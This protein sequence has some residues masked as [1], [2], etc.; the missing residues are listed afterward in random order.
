MRPHLKYIRGE[1]IRPVCDMLPKL[2]QLRILD[3]GGGH[4]I[5]ANTIAEI[6]KCPVDV[7]DL[8]PGAIECGSWYQQDICKP[9]PELQN[10]YTTIFANNLIHFLAER[11]QFYLAVFKY[12]RN[13]GR[14]V[15]VTKSHQ[16][17]RDRLVMSFFQ[18]SGEA[19]L[20]RFPG[21]SK[22]SAELETFGFAVERVGDV[23]LS[24]FELNEYSL[25]FC[26]ESL[27]SSIR[28]LDK[29]TFEQGYRKLSE[30]VNSQQSPTVLSNWKAV[31]VAKRAS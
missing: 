29:A 27:W 21:I 19:D 18:G 30:Y 12:L 14:L 4:G 23:E 22:I 20:I 6:M 9:N 11:T 5:H 31:I 13:E 1:D 8:L 10:R 15:I 28:I 7:L 17:I 25:S 2:A 3:A 26:R 24:R 16:Q